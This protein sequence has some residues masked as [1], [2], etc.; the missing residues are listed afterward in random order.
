MS[1]SILVDLDTL[2]QFVALGIWA[3]FF[4]GI[5]ATT[6]VLWA[7]DGISALVARPFAERLNAGRES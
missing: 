3:G 7:V 4:A 5:L 1:T 2:K 6:A